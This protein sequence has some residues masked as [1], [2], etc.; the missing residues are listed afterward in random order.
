M[1]KMNM[2][3]LTHLLAPGTLNSIVSAACAST[4]FAWLWLGFQ[5]TSKAQS[6]GESSHNGED[7]S[8]DEA[9]RGYVALLGLVYER[10]HELRVRRPS[11]NSVDRYCVTGIADKARSILAD[12]TNRSLTV[13]PP[14]AIDEN[15]RLS[16]GS[17]LCPGGHL[18]IAPPG[19]SYFD[20]LAAYESTIKA[21]Y[22]AYPFPTVEEMLLDSPELRQR[23]ERVDHYCNESEVAVPFFFDIT[24]MRAPTGSQ[25]LFQ[26]SNVG[27]INSKKPEDARLALPIR[28]PRTTNPW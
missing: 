23:V 22:N 24:I 19:Y 5:D 20:S 13:D 8:V 14:Q 4:V 3:M 7:L 28:D 18:Y 21:R 1:R 6:V 27:C 17:E 25:M 26:L 10:T 16:S 12:L 15:Y 2:R 11:I 9:Q